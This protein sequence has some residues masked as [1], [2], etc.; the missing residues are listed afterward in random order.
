MYEEDT[1]SA[2]QSL[3]LPS[4]VKADRPNL[5]P[6]SKFGPAES[7]EA[8]LPH[9]AH[10]RP[11]L[12]KQGHSDQLPR[13]AEC[14]GA[15]PTVNPSLPLRNDLRTHF[16]TSPYT[17]PKAIG[18]S[19]LPTG[20]PTAASTEA[21]SSRKGLGTPSKPRYAVARPLS[22]LVDPV[23]SDLNT[24]T[25]IPR[26]YLIPETMAA[27][28]IETQPI[29]VD[30]STQML[31][32]LLPPASNVEPKPFV[33]NYHQNWCTNHGDSP[34]SWETMN[35]TTNIAHLTNAL[36]SH[37]TSAMH[38]S[39]L[40]AADSSASI[41]TN[42]NANNQQTIR[43]SKGKRLHQEKIDHSRMPKEQYEATR[44][45]RVLGRWLAQQEEWSQLSQVLSSTTRA[46]PSHLLLGHTSSSAWRQRRETADALEV[47]NQ[48][49]Q[50][51]APDTWQVT[52]R[53]ES[54]TFVSVG[55]HLSGLYCAVR[56]HR[57]SLGE[58]IRPGISLS[59][60]YDTPSSPY[61]NPVSPGLLIEGTSLTA[62]VR[63]RANLPNP[64]LAN[65]SLLTKAD[66]SASGASIT[67]FSSSMPSSSVCCGIKADDKAD[68]RIDGGDDVITSTDED[69]VDPFTQFVESTWTRGTDHADH[70]QIPS[71]HASCQSSTPSSSSSLSTSPLLGPAISVSHTVLISTIPYPR[72]CRR[73]CI[74]IR[75]IGTTSLLL[76][77]YPVLPSFCRNDSV[78]CSTTTFSLQPGQIAQ[79]PFILNPI[80]PGISH[81][82]WS[83]ASWPSLSVVQVANP[84]TTLLHS[85]S[86]PT[87]VSPLSY[88]LTI[89]TI[90]LPSSTPL[91]SRD[92]LLKYLE[93]H[94]VHRSIQASL[95]DLT[96]QLPLPLSPS[97]QYLSSFFTDNLHAAFLRANSHR[98]L[99]YHPDLVADM[100]SLAHDVLMLH[101][102]RCRSNM[103]WDLNVDTLQS[104]I[105]AI[106][107]RH[108][109]AIPPYLARF[110]SLL[111]RA[112]VRTEPTTWRTRL[113]GQLLTESVF[114]HIHRLHV[115]CSSLPAIQSSY[116][117]PPV[118][119]STTSNPSA[120]EA[121]IQSRLLTACGLFAS[122]SHHG[123][124]VRR[125]LAHVHF[126]LS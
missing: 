4:I 9:V 86:S 115:S 122:A 29:G 89:R 1:P 7:D 58:A 102:L 42:I 53:G 108:E 98:R 2:I 20:I 8:N 62:Y 118:N 19:Q 110:H 106:P 111:T 33:Q 44:Q 87:H 77:W 12:V 103:V 31:P 99:H 50:Q 88:K 51:A 105:H 27:M 38:R 126:S 100:C 57:P 78:T 90:C 124:Q 70:F 97:N 52:L 49:G 65:G 85:S 125:S 40:P 10:R 15:G 112:S 60:A 47:A 17:R 114:A 45:T 113:L 59:Q 41:N 94:S 119:R 71:V 23:N 81:S 16:L 22:Q 21:I 13:S 69:A 61:T 34:T 35:A 74:T 64:T 93:A 55:N 63:G 11:F 56:R 79:C 116:S 36:N 30:L 26:S 48:D 120:L 96:S 37:F 32:P 24:L 6:Y 68:D 25:S 92:I 5:R 43:E 84:S 107:I 72:A 76:R 83:L 82:V 75:N 66:G 18:V 121:N 3:K 109:S 54:T 46:H 73:E 104:L 67:A 123:N 28:A 14:N 95:I 117:D 91:I 101:P 39:T 80:A